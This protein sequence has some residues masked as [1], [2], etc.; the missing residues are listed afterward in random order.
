[1]AAFD[2]STDPFEAGYSSRG[3][4]SWTKYS[5]PSFSGSRRSTDLRAVWTCFPFW[6]KT[7]E[8]FLWTWTQLSNFPTSR[9]C[10]RATTR[11]SFTCW[12]MPMESSPSLLSPKTPLISSP[13][14]SSPTASPTSSQNNI[15]LEWI[16]WTNYRRNTSPRSSEWS[17]T[18]EVSASKKIL[19]PESVLPPSSPRELTFWDSHRTSIR[20]SCS[21]PT[22]RR[23]VLPWR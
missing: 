12:S 20:S 19:S 16:L 2:S 4:S 1:M 23:R 14:T 21:M 18:P 3:S 8:W 5:L 10:C 13:S 15:K 7:S 17:T 9:M 22:S 6:P 11:T